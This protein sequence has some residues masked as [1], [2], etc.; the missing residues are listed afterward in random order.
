MFLIIYLSSYNFFVSFDFQSNCEIQLYEMLECERQKYTTR[1]MR[2]TVY[3]IA[4]R[5]HHFLEII[6]EDLRNAT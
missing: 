4:E 5:Q 3:F 2:R 6:Y 1:E